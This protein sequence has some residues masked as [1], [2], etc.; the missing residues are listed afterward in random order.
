M[1]F[2][3]K[4]VVNSNG[5]IDLLDTS[6]ASPKGCANPSIIKHKDRLLLTFRS[7]EYTFFN[8]RK[9]WYPQISMDLCWYP[10]FIYP[11][12]PT[13]YFSYNYICE[14]DKT[15]N[16]VNNPKLL[17]L[18][19]ETRFNQ[20]N[21][22][23]D[24]RLFIDEY[25]DLCMTYST[26]EEG[27]VKMNISKFDDDFNIVVNDK[28]SKNDQYEKNWM[29]VLDK[30]GRLMRK[31]FDT[32]VTVKRPE[33][34]SHAEFECTNPDNNLTLCGSA[35]MSKINDGYIT[36]VHNKKHVNGYDG[37]TTLQYVHKFVITDNEFKVI[38]ES[39][40]FTFTG[41]PI[42]FT[43]GMHIENDDVLLPISVFDCASF[44]IKT[45]LQTI[46]DFIDGKEKEDKDP[47]DATN[48]LET[49]ICERD[50]EDIPKNMALTVIMDCKSNYAA[51]IA[52]KT[53]I[54]AEAKSVASAKKYY[55]DSLCDIKK[56][57]NG[58]D[59]KY[60]H[61]LLGQDIIRDMIDKCNSFL[62]Y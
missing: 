27:K 49:I 52:C 28:Y 51:Q 5:H 12:V 55:V 21:G 36:L 61:M 9:N 11:N 47:W 13:N 3:F 35:Q 50:Y 19:E 60:M 57:D 32:V 17:N 18:C 7:C 53:Y 40:W 37:R 31:A 24:I 8:F 10:L 45:N 48:D 44:M 26:F 59:N 33:R 23:E 62:L 14:Y 46:F 30:S 1:K 29:P 43:C 20:F 56:F 25:D 16:T 54:A 15:S 4:Y 38:K 22:A 34:Y 2:F 58:M 41:L 42:E 39:E 6:F